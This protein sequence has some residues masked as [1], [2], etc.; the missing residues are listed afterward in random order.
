MKTKTKKKKKYIYIYIRNILKKQKTMLYPMV[1]RVETID[2]K[3]RQ[4][5]FKEFLGSYS[6]NMIKFHRKLRSILITGIHK[7]T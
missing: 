3:L 4:K 7:I 1:I 5:L 2:G 6:K